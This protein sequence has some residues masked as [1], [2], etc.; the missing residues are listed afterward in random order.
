MSAGWAADGKNGLERLVLKDTKSGSCVEIYRFGATIT[1]CRL[2]GKDEMLFVSKEAVYD[3]KKAIRGGVPVV[4]PQFGPGAL[5]NHGFARTSEWELRSASDDG[6]AEFELNPTDESLKMWPHQFRLVYKVAVDATSLRTTL[7][8]EN[9][10]KSAFPFCALLHT[11]HQVP[12]LHFKKLRVQGLLG[13]YSDKTRDMATLEHPAG[14]DGEAASGGK[15][16]GFGADLAMEEE[17]DRV[18]GQFWSKARKAMPVGREEK[19]G[20]GAGGSGSESVPSLVVGPVGREGGSLRQA[21]VSAVGRVL[22]PSGAATGS[23]GDSK[24]G[25]AAA[26][27]DEG[28]DVVVWNPWIEKGK[29]MD[30]FGDDEYQEMVCVEPGRVSEPFDLEAGASYELEQVIEWSEHEA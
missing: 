14:S 20:G 2:G 10:G 12:R 1:S 15:G 27:V 11:Y 6:L 22:P 7:C 3:G 23:E 8:V 16:E 24:E 25:A 30:D 5:P 21:R 19:E 9:T 28:L 13:S 29:R 26:V 17:T 4:F 18:Y